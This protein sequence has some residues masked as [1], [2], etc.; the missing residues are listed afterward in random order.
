M[1]QIIKFIAI[2]PGLSKTQLLILNFA[3]IKYL[4]EYIFDEESIIFQTILEMF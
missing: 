2:S 1:N 4:K 3:G